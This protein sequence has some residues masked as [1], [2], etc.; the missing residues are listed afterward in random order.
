MKGLDAASLRRLDAPEVN[1]SPAAL[2]WVEEPIWNQVLDLLH[3]MSARPLKHRYRFKPPQ[4]RQLQELL[5]EDFTLDPKRLFIVGIAID[6]ALACFREDHWRLPWLRAQV[7]PAQVAMLSDVSNPPPA[8]GQ[9]TPLA[10]ARRWLQHLWYVGRIDTFRALGDLPIPTPVKLPARVALA[11]EASAQRQR[12]RIGLAQWP[13]HRDEGL[14]ID[15]GSGTFAVRGYRDPQEP[16]LVEL[17][18]AARA[19]Q[20]DV[21]L[22]PE[23]ALDETRLGE[24][25][26]ALKQARARFPILVAAGLVHAPV[27]SEA[28][29]FCNQPSLPT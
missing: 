14:V 9:M 12:C 4:L 8:I 29:V 18:A 13:H 20:L 16:A 7:L 27:P 24:L 17:V 21:L 22:L 28:P 2:G 26:Q 19:A 3:L 5:G 15:R 23:I 10:I 6:R 25:Q 1:R 11:L